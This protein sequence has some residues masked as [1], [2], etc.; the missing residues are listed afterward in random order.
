MQRE[1]VNEI[2]LMRFAAALM[3][4]F[5]HYAFRGY[6]GGDR[7]EMPY[8]LL[9]P[10]AK[11][12]YLGVELFFM[13]SGFVILMTAASGTLRSF[14]ISRF[15]RLYPAFWACCTVTFLATLII[16]GDRFHASVGQY[17]INMTMLSGFL[18]VP[19]IDGVYWSLFIELQF[20]A[21]VA[22]L[23]ALGQIPRAQIWLYLWLLAVLVAQ[24][25]D[26]PRLRIMLI[27]PYAAYFIAGATC[28][29]IRTQG[30]NAA[31]G[32]LLT[33][34]WLLAL[35][36][37]T[38]AVGWF[39]RRF[40]TDF[41]TFV[42]AAIITAFFLMMLAVATRRTGRFA[43]WRWV[44]LGSLTYPL[45]LLHQNIGYM[46]FN[47]IYPQVNAHLLFWGTIALM[48][49]MSYA[50]HATVER[51]LSRPLKAGLNSLFDALALV[52]RPWHGWISR[53]G[54]GVPL[55]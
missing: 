52:W 35:Y 27:A 19:P 18:H 40:H 2:D 55:D 24:Y 45:Y 16:G 41:S 1:R 12:G 29:L 49:V 32:G 42:V 4:V 5:Y 25:M 37:F 28:Y 6:A 7:S 13:I 43:H 33:A 23:L 36:Q 50:V 3:V 51:P 14:A 39:E 20:Y 26:I 46:V 48:L 38:R 17:L 31:R 47:A 21:F 44:A 10:V 15:V 34:S 11:Y 8:A 22:L 30:I 9:A 54:R 53:F